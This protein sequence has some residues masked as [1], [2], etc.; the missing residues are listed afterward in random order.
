MERVA[1]DDFVK[2]SK[3]LMHIIEGDI[4]DDE[5]AEGLEILIHYGLI[6]EDEEWIY[7]EE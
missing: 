1:W 4:F 2:I 6:N 5:L 3:L 7:E